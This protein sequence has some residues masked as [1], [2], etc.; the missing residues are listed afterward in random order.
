VSR[1]EPGRA[2]GGRRV[3]RDDLAR[4]SPE[5]VESLYRDY[6]RD[7]GS[8]DERWA[9]VFAGYDLGRQGTAGG[10]SPD[11]GPGGRGDEAI[12]DLVRDMIH[13]YRE[14]GHLVADL[15]PLGQSPR[16]HP[17]LTLEEFGFGPDDLDRV[18][19]WAPFR[20]G[21]RGALRQLIAALAETYGDTLGVEY[22][23]ISDKERRLW[24]QARMEPRRNRPDLDADDRRRIVDRLL[25]AEMF[26]QFLQAR[27]PGQQRFSLEGGESLIPLLDALV[28]EA[29]RRGVAEMVI[30]IPH[31]GR[32]NVLAHVLGKPYE[33]IFA[34]FEGAPLPEE[35]QGDGDVKYHL[36]YSHNHRTRRGRQ[37]HLSLSP[38]PSH[39]EAVNPVVEGIVRAKQGY[40]GDVERRRVVPVLLHGDAA[41]TGQGL[42]YETLA[43][44]TLPSFT[45]GGTVHVIVDNQIGFTTLPRD[46][47]FTRYPSDP[48]HVIHAPVFHVNGDDPEAAVQAAR[49][50]VGYRQQ[51]RGDVFIHFVCYRRHGHNELDDPTL[52]QPVMYERIRHHPSVLERYRQRLGARG[53]LDEVAVRRMREARRQV[54]DTA[55]QTARR[56]RPRQQVL[57]LGGVWSGLDWA[58]DDWS[59]DTRVDRARLVA[60]A[61]AMSRLPDDFTPHPRVQK[62]LDERRERVQRGERIDWATAELLAFGSLLLE[63]IPVRLSGQDSVRGT[64]TQRHAAVFDA[65]EGGAYVPLNH[66]ASDQAELEAVNSPL[67]EA[68]VLGFEYGMSS[69]DPRRLVVWEAQF[70]DFINSAQVVIDQFVASAESK[71]QRMSGIVLL[72]PHGYEGQGPEHSSAR[73][74]R[75]LQLAA[76]GN[77]QVVNASTPAQIFHVLRRQVHRRFRKPL[78]V[79]SP[80]SLLRHPHAVSTL[81]ELAGGTFRLV[82]DDDAVRDPA[83]VRR[84]LLCSGKVFYALAA[85]RA[86]GR[87]DGVAIVRLEQLYP[88][89]TVELERVIRRY[90]EAAAVVWAQEEPANQGPWRF[91]QPPIIEVLGG[92]RS[93]VYAGRDEA[94]SPAT[95]NYQIHH[96]EETAILARGLGDSGAVARAPGERRGAQDR[97]SA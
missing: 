45:T 62:L 14:L 31:R 80:K 13:S 24:L 43:L 92:G 17:L 95:G 44:S 57:A 87:G 51:F 90:P 22:M 78:I 18:V 61:E 81:D 52:T 58:G 4:A 49:L 27:Y 21:E 38:N 54:L 94:A 5:Y 32:L 64:F 35:V 83:S 82:L 34:E 25:A 65:K 40:L 11:G 1:P 47:V 85:A 60:V 9:L 63:R 12:L 66:L 73:V 19:A 76:E 97:A 29:A 67:S 74:E 6:R 33:M 59:A 8:V 37:I 53:E 10:Q 36:G 15:D 55:L 93:L 46:Y 86:D 84:V 91:V 41:F 50:A 77:I 56:D 23:A 7:P 75:F 16:R 72:L 2:R 70:G 96:E 42:V 71:W 39:L 88:F 69:A 26:E 48:G 68:G 20:G 30:G 3:W 89:P 28:E 79:M